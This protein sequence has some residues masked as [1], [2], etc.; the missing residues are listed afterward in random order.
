MT[1]ARSYAQTVSWPVA[2]PALFENGN[3]VDSC[4]WEHS[5]RQ[6]GFVFPSHVLA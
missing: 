6:H 1:G 4:P 3:D 2:D 5:I